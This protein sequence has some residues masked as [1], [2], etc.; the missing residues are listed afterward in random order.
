ML[1][2]LLQTLLCSPVPFCVFDAFQAVNCWWSS[3]LFIFLFFS[4]HEVKKQIFFSF[5]PHRF[6][7]SVTLISERAR[8]PLSP[9]C[10]EWESV[11][12]SCPCASPV[13]H[14]QGSSSSTEVQ[15]DGAHTELLVP[16]L[17]ALTFVASRYG[18][19]G[20][21]AGNQGEFLGLLP[22]P[23]PCALLRDGRFPG[24]LSPEGIQSL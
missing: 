10:W 14:L 23:G 18:Q 3:P 11:L 20:A 22:L 13:S 1:W 4:L 12:G 16:G 21:D 2:T 8:I 15:R 7:R 24:F 6:L 9:P 5:F 17:W 19:V